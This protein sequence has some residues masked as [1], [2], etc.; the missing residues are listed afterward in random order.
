MMREVLRMIRGNKQLLAILR[1]SDSVDKY[2]RELQRID[3]SLLHLVYSKIDESSCGMME[4]R[5]DQGFDAKTLSEQENRE[6]QERDIQFFDTLKDAIGSITQSIDNLN[7]KQLMQTKTLIREQIFGCPDS[8]AKEHLAGWIDEVVANL[9]KAL[10]TCCEDKTDE[11]DEA[12]GKLSCLL[13]EHSKRLPPSAFATLATAEILYNRYAIKEYAEEGFDYSSISAL[14]YQAFE[15]A[16]NEMIWKPYADWIN[17][18]LDE[19]ADDPSIIDKLY[20]EYLPG[21][22]DNVKKYYYFKSG[23]KKEDP[24]RVV[25]YCVFGTFYHLLKEVYEKNTAPTFREW[26]SFLSG[27]DKVTEMLEDEKFKSR[28][29]IFTR[30]VFEATPNRNNASHGG[31]IIS[32]EQCIQDKTTIINELETVRSNSL[33]LIQQLLLIIKRQPR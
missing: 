30:N 29:A 23:P 2:R 8:I 27:Y 18:Q 10:V 32:I 26:F 15:E 14:Y 24:R 5:E 16:Y 25:T 17:Q 12:K 31:S 9:C 20:L 19:T 6:G 21:N 11:F 28:V 3:E 1:M 22:I 4:Y 33:G 13:G 7:I